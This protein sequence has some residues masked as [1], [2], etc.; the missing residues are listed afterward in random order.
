[1]QVRKFMV[2]VV[3]RPPFTAGAQL[4][5]E[6][7]AFQNADGLAAAPYCP[8]PARNVTVTVK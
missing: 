4:L 6:A 3:L 8:V 5:F 2:T 7:E 1:M